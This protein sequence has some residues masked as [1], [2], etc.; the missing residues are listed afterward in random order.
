MLNEHT[1]GAA[2]LAADDLRR[3]VLGDELRVFRLDGLEAQH[4]LVVLVI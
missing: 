2:R 1:G 3:R 4:E